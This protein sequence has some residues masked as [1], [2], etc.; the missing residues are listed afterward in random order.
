M[1]AWQEFQQQILYPV[2]PFGGAQIAGLASI[3]K[4]RRGARAQSCAVGLC[5]EA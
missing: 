2:H 5:A 4:L 3:G 1:Q